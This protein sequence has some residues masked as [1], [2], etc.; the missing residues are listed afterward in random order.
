LAGISAPPVPIVCV[1]VG[2]KG[3]QERGAADGWGPRGSEIS[4]GYV[5][6]MLVC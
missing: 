1:T 2:K 4:K 5:G 3:T 6:N